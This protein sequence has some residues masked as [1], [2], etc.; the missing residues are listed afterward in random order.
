VDASHDDGLPTL[1]RA[2]DEEEWTENGL[3][4]LSTTVPKHNEK[5][6]RLLNLFRRQYEFRQVIEPL[7]KTIEFDARGVPA[8][9]WPAGKRLNV[10]VDPSRAFGQPI[11]AITKVP[12]AVL[13]TAA[14]SQSI[15]EVAKTYQ[16]PQSSVRHAVEFESNLGLKR[17]A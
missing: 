1:P 7:L 13:A 16:V 2:A 3:A 5:S 4:F 6:E 9:W 12:T 8:L 17:A 10:V 15:E 11:D 14:K